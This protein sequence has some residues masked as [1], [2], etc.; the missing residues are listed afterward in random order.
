MEDKLMTQQ[1][2]YYCII[3]AKVRYAKTISP[4]AKLLYGEITALCNQEGYCWASN[5]YFA[6]L[7]GVSKTSVSKWVNQLK[8]QGF[9]T[10]ELRYKK[11]SKEID[12]RRIRIVEEPIKEKEST[13]PTKVDDRMKEKFKENTITNTKN[14]NTKNKKSACRYTESQLQL[15]K[16]FQSN[17]AKDFPREMSRVNVSR[18]AN[19]LRRI[20][21]EENIEMS[22]IEE[23]ITWLAT[24]DFWSRHVRNPNVLQEKFERLLVEKKAQQSKKLKQKTESLPEW[25]NKRISEHR[26]SPEEE[27]ELQQK[28]QAFNQMNV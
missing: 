16:R 1:P 7:Y 18:W 12:Q 27:R 22:E 24:H 4:N 17:L 10:V 19:D 21:E 5:D 20:H 6:T 14:N 15:A 11:D 26:V 23:M 13:S 3:P 25:V 9:I 8:E 28:I 2:N